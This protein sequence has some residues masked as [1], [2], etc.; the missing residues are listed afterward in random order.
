[1]AVPELGLVSHVGRLVEFRYE[2]GA[3]GRGKLVS[4]DPDDLEELTYELSEIIRASPSLAASTA[5]GASIVVDLHQFTDDCYLV[6]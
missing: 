6:E 3:I 5:I 4:I 1:M 2:D